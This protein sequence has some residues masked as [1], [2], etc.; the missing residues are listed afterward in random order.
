MADQKNRRHYKIAIIPGDVIGKEV[1]P[2]GRAVLEAATT[3]HG[4]DL[5]LD[6][7]DFASRIVFDWRQD[8]RRCAA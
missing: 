3:R 2:E 6:T 5:T 8:V 7:F 4:F 1:M